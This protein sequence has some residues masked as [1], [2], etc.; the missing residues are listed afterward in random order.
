MRQERKKGECCQWNLGGEDQQ[1]VQADALTL[2]NA[3][4]GPFCS[5]VCCLEDWSFRLSRCS[6]AFLRPCCCHFSRIKQAIRENGMYFLI[7]LKLFVTGHSKKLFQVIIQ[8]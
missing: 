8:N 2:G 7:C 4:Q 3:G 5:F 6:L 1:E